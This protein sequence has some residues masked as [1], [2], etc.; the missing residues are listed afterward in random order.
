MQSETGFPSSHQLKSYVASKSRL[1]LAARA[2]LSADAGL[3]VI[4]LIDSSVLNLTMLKGTSAKY[5]TFFVLAWKSSIMSM[6]HHHGL[7]GSAS[8]VLTA[9]GSV[10]GKGKFSTPYGI[11]SPQPITKTLVTGN[12]LG[13][14]YSCAK[15]GA[16]MST[17][18]FWANGWNTTKIISINL[19]MPF[20]E[21]T[22][23]SDASTDF[24]AWWLKWRGLAQGCAF[25]GFVDIA[26]HLG[27]KIPKD[28]FGGMNRRFQA[29]L[30]KLK[31]MH[32]IET[33][34]PIPTKFCTAIKATKC[35]S[36]VVRTHT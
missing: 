28:N 20:W 21:L 4:Y 22:Y 3:L 32:I 9:T 2:V 17:G 35:P 15:F 23:R 13:D 7:R 29:K 1:K 31:N 11:D 26:P 8:P 30:A 5:V 36:W 27:G 25:L 24:C 16:H 19:F 6:A 18:S 33:S 12:Y 10:K 14:P 34:A